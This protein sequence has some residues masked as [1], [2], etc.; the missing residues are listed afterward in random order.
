MEITLTLSKQTKRT[1]VYTE[2]DNDLG[3]ESAVPTLYVKTAAL[4]EAFGNIPEELIIEVS[5]P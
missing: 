5:V 1:H 4:K 3:L 2:V